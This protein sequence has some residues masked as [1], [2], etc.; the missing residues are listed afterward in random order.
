MEN[1]MSQFLSLAINPEKII[2]TGLKTEYREA[3]KD[4]SIIIMDGTYIHGFDCDDKE[5]FCFD[6]HIIKGGNIEVKNFKIVNK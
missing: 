2:L 5:M 4:T 1:E 3:I 6:P